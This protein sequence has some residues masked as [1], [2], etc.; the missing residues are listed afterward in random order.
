MT[1]L[2][3]G[4]GAW[5]SGIILWFIG[6]NWDRNWDLKQKSETLQPILL[7]QKPL[8]G[9]SVWILEQA[10][11]SFS[12]YIWLPGLARLEEFWF[13]WNC[14]FTTDL[15]CVRQTNKMSSVS[16]AKQISKYSKILTAD[17]QVK[18]SVCL[19]QPINI[20]GDRGD[21][22]RLRLTQHDNFHF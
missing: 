1:W 18:V 9:M 10:A 5:W 6:R 15:L 20:T 14:G 8:A 19:Y 11:H 12:Y 21:G 4:G 7:E 2:W 16:K 17:M 3:S 22:G 13:W